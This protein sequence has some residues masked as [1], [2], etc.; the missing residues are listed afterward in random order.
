MPAR[1]LDGNQI[2]SEIKQE[3]RLQIN[4]SKPVLAVVLV[5]S[6]PASEIY[7]KRKCQACEEVG[8]ESHVVRLFPQ[9]ILNKFQDMEYIMKSIRFLNAGS[10]DGVMVQFPLPKELGHSF[11]FDVLDAIDPKKDVDALTPTNMGLL[12][13]G[14]PRFVPCTPAGVQEMLI[15][16]G[17]PLKGKRVCI[18]NRSDIVGKPLQAL[19]SQ[20]NDRANATV[21]MCHDNTPSDVLTRTCLDSDIVIVAVGKPNFLTSNMVTEKTVVVDVGI[22]RQNGKIVGDVCPEVLQKAAVAT[23]VPGGVGPLTVAMLLKNTV[24]A[25]NGDCN[26]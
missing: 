15:R 17:I 7:V 21:T 26:G 5:G 25:K 6:D 2:A 8:I 16:S 4:D 11:K 24:L 18:I 10:A 9:G 13:Q 20:D 19:L 3:L 14:R 23:K 1:I 22:N 12:L